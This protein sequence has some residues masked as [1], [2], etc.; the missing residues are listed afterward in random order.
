QTDPNTGN[1][2]TPTEVNVSGYTYVAYLF[3]HNAG[4]F[5]L[6]G[7]D[8]VISCGSFTTDSGGNV[9]VTLGYEPQWVLIRQSDGS[10]DWRIIDT[11]RGWTT[12]TGFEYLKA[13]TSDAEASYT[14]GNLPP[15]ATGFSG[16]YPPLNGLANYIYIAI[17]RGPMKV[18]TSGTSVF[19]TRGRAGDNTSS[20]LITPST[21]MTTDMTLTMNRSGG[22]GGSAGAGAVGGFVN[23]DRL[24]GYKAL[25]TSS[26]NLEPSPGA[27]GFNSSLTTT[28]TTQV[29]RIS[30][31]SSVVP[32]A[33]LMW[34][35]IRGM[36][37]TAGQSI[38]V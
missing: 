9:N 32:P 28:P 27:V 35:A 7:S 36:A 13:N 1:N 5:G 26:S 22:L 29:T 19:G 24:R 33:S 2:V 30:T 8:N 16:S 17:R 18:P 31:T 15:N 11:M 21:D 4:G 25:Y 3:A 38:I 23:F 10:S 12:P 37:P 6:S 14:S 34:F 20:P